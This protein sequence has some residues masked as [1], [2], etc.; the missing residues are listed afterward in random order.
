MA[1]RKARRPHALELQS[2]NGHSFP[3]TINLLPRD[4]MMMRK[5]RN[6]HAAHTHRRDNPHLVLIPPPT[7]PLQPENISTHHRPPHKTRR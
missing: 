3:L 4:L 1:K 6:R 7:S 2:L 5:L